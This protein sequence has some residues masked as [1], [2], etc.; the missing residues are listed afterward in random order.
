MRSIESPYSSI[1]LS[2]Q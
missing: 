1:I 2:D